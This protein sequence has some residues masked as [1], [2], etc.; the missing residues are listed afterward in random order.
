MTTADSSTRR[1]VTVCG[2]FLALSVSV[3]ARPLEVL[4]T[5]ARVRS[6]K[7]VEANEE[8]P[9]HLRG[10]VTYFDRAAPEF[11]LQDDSGGIWIRWSPELPEP[12]AG[13]LIDLRGST[14]QIDFAPDI[15][16]PIWTVIGH[17]ELPRPK[18][19]TFEE[20]AST[21][22]DAQFVEI[23]GTVRRVK[24]AGGPRGRTLGAPEQLFNLS[25]FMQGGSVDVVV[26][27]RGQ[28]LPV[29]LT[30]TEV[31]VRGVCGAEF[32]PK[33]QL[34]GVS[35][36]AQKLD[37]ITVLS[38]PEGD[39]F[40]SEALSI[41]SLQRFG[42]QTDLGKQVKVTGIVTAT[43]DPTTAYIAD[44]SGGLLMELRDESALKPGD[45]IQALG[46]PAFEHGIVKLEDTS[47]RRISSGRPAAPKPLTAEQAMT[48]EAD[49]LL[50]RM[51]GKVLSR[52][53]LPGQETLVLK[54]GQQ[55]YSVISK[56][57]GAIRVPEG[58]TVQVV[59]I[60]V[61]DFDAHQQPLG[62]RLI[63]RSPADIL[64]IRQPSWWTLER[65][66]V[67]IAILALGT[68]FAV[69]WIA[70]L[71]R[72]I[73]QKTE[74]LRATIE[75][76][77]EGI[78]VVDSSGDV[79]AHNQKLLQICHGPTT[80]A[81][82][83]EN[84]Q[85]EKLLID[86]LLDAE[87]FQVKLIELASNAKVETD[88]IIQLKDGR[89]LERHSEPL[90][91]RGKSAGR[92]WSF[93]DVTE[94]HRA[95]Q[96]LAA[97][98]VAA[99]SA[100]R[101]KSE[102]LANM[103]HEIRTPMNGIM[104][105]T[106]L[107]LATALDREQREY[108]DTVRES[109]DSLLTILN[110]VLDFSKI[111]AGKVSIEPV[112]TE[113]RTELHTMLRILAVRAHQK[114][115]ELVCD[116]D[117]DVPSFA[118][119]DFHRVRQV[120]VN[121]IGNAIKFTARGEVELRVSRETGPA[122]GEGLR[123]TV[124]DTGIGIDSEQLSNIFKPFV[125]ADGSTSRNFGGTGLGLTISRRL[126]ELMNSSI[127]VQSKP[128][129]GSTFS[130]LLPCDI[131]QDD[132]A[133]QPPAAS[134]L[135][136]LAVEPNAAGQRVL[137]KMLA[138]HN[139]VCHCA[140]TPL[141]A[142]DAIRDARAKGLDYHAVLIAAELNGA[143]G[144]ELAQQIRCQSPLRNSPFLVMLTG[145]DLQ[146]VNEKCSQAGV[147]A[148]LVKPV[149][150]AELAK[151]LGEIERGK[152]A[153]GA[154]SPVTSKRPAQDRL[155]ILIAEDNPV[156]ALLASK[157]LT[158]QGHQVEVAAN[159]IVAVEKS[160]LRSYDAILMDVQMPGMDG[161]EATRAIRRRDNLAGRHVPIFAVTAHA[162]NGYRELCLEAGMDGYLTKPI[163]SDE[164]FEILN[165][166]VGQQA[167]LRS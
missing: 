17:A 55:L 146:A 117:A 40:N 93:R 1:V 57:P 59:G 14:T 4:T 110:D 39:P 166:I 36:Y 75:S 3:M 103:S 30:D 10:I 13:E 68:L 102:F 41:D 91:S 52:A 132:R 83:V 95:E 74:A 141:A 111:E 149:A 5:A 116:V 104:G 67:F 164:L 89:T 81:G 28:A 148:Y 69:C 9:V 94:R 45:Q 47:V 139:A 96:E 162:L 126:L 32:S 157:L 106:E 165:A 99:E 48:G 92:V 21:R 115:L 119:L 18:R 100:N 22:E 160:A 128:G 24:F 87:S 135:R 12:H 155:S 80:L 35:L 44:G 2:L 86:Q 114:K 31:R 15:A 156:N 98:K 133:P 37:Q 137:G 70:I 7:A 130:F 50:V 129:E 134:P 26:P 16:N 38:R 51:E 11:F 84:W 77:E 63:A 79:I 109:A 151:V 121:L 112:R 145:S 33:N 154:G 143:S 123:F 107:A 62:F 140:A 43:L 122:T 27:S 56:G 138:E 90:R 29:D 136:V 34:V 61:N 97:A 153:E 73:G 71:K 118:V 72:E 42:F 78:L 101:S 23:V 105:M 125:Q 113:L 58:S 25:L 163:Q 131:G 127:E 60:C 88:D 150:S 147:A 8:Y 20:M 65:V 158:K 159:G 144:F 6:L 76:I 64:V 66:F 167:S 85:A 82:G 19:V 49:S 120:L 46:Y 161:F 142:L 152:P 53:S 124:R 54:Q 108:I